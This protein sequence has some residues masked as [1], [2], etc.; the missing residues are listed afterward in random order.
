MH[1]PL[2][3]VWRGELLESMHFG[4]LVELSPDDSMVRS[5]GDVETAM[6]PRSASKLMQAAGCVELGLDIEP[7]LLALVA[8]SHSGGDVH[9]AGVEELLAG[10]GL[11]AVN[12]HNPPGLPIGK[13]ERKAY[14]MSGGTRA[15]L[16]GD[17]SGKHAGFLATCVINGWTTADYLSPTHPLQIALRRQVESATG[18]AVQYDSV[19]GCGA[20]LWSTTLHGLAR[21][22]GNAVKA[23]EGSALRRVADAMRAFP[24]LVGGPGRAA[25]VAMQSA[26]GLLAKDGAEAVFAMARA[27]GAAAAFKIADGGARALPPLVAD[28][29]RRW[30]ADGSQLQVEPVLGGGAPVGRL[31]LRLQ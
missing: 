18:E 11:S 8:A 24:E 17:C 21:A 27:D 20:P 30:G 7:R 25:T 5:A 10:F 6:F 31:A 4:S 16:R 14:L 28:Q 3:E 1:V 12:L 19:D 29:L 2:V 13:P 26:P 22:Y 9:V 15:S 23:P